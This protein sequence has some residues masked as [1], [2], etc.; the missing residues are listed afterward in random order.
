MGSLF[1]WAASIPTSSNEPQRNHWLCERSETIWRSDV[2]VAYYTSRG[3]LYLN[4]EVV[5]PLELGFRK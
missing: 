5:R 3:I 2:H 4:L 1:S